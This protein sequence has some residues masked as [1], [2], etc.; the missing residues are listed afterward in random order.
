[1][2]I[3]IIAIIIMMMMMMINFLKPFYFF[4]EGDAKKKITKDKRLKKTP[5]A[6]NL[7]YAN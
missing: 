6:L 4:I 2:V 1:M 5:K 7:I 3:L